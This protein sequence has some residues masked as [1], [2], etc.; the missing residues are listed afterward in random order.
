M[1]RQRTRVAQTGFIIIIIDPVPCHGPSTPRTLFSRGRRRRRCTIIS[2][3]ILITVIVVVTTVSL[4]TR[5]L[6]VVQV[7][8]VV[9]GCGA[10]AKLGMAQLFDPVQERHDA[11]GRA[12]AGFCILVGRVGSVMAAR[13]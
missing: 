3:I 2:V 4:L 1:T 12:F 11:G 7:H 5:L 10:I 9:T 8:V 13:G 6:V